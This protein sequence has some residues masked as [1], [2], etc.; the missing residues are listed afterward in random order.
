MVGGALVHFFLG[1][2][3]L[4]F[5][6]RTAKVIRAAPQEA[7]GETETVGRAGIADQVA[8]WIDGAITLTGLGL[9]VVNQSS[10]TNGY[11]VAGLIIWGGAVACYFVSGIIV[12]EVGGVPLSM[13]YGGW[14]IRRNRRGRYRS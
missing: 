10:E 3:G 1:L 9:V 12:R 11:A 5:V 13:G 4:V 6:Y 2:A 14:A 8:Q 7:T